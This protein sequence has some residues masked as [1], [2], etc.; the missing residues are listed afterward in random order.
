MSSLAIKQTLSM[1]SGS[2]NYINSDD[3]LVIDMGIR[4][5]ILGVRLSILT[6]GLGLAK[7]KSKRLFKNLGFRSMLEYINNL[8]TDTKMYRSGIYNWLNIGEAYIKY[9]NELEQIGFNESHGPTKLSYLD[10]ALAIRQKQEVFDNI[11]DMSLREFI[12]FAKGGRAQT[13]SD[14]MVHKKPHIIFKGN[15]VYINGKRAIIINKNL[16]NKTTKYF[17]KVIHVACEAL[18]KGGLVMPLFMRN[19][20]ETLRFKQAYGSI[21]AQVRKR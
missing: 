4:D 5:T 1:E 7:I 20:R 14:G 16:G 21:M 12:D 10:R 18:E 13:L 6:M 3:A 2:L 15:V 19:K 11:K 17:L 8:S 9:R